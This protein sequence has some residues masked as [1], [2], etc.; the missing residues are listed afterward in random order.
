MTP[1][2]VPADVFNYTLVHLNQHEEYNVFVDVST[3]VGYNSTAE[4]AVITIPPMSSGRFFM[5]RSTSSQ[6]NSLGCIQVS[7]QQYRRFCVN[8]GKCTLFLY[9]PYHT[10]FCT[11]FIRSTVVGHVLTVHSCFLCAAIT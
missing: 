8:L 5:R 6:I 11:I 1:D 4:T 9:S 10:L 7:W 2:L 3:I